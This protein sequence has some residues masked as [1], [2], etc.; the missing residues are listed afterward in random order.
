M[1]TFTQAQAEQ[2]ESLT[3]RV[4]NILLW[5]A[6]LAKVAGYDSRLNVRA[7]TTVKQLLRE[8]ARVSHRN[9]SEFL[10]DQRY[11]LVNQRPTV[12]RPT[13]AARVTWWSASIASP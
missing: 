13:P 1:L 9:V 5:L 7:S 11:A 12:R 6:K 3:Q 8:A 2:P 10:L 4:L